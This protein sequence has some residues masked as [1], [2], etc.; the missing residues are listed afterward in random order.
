[1]HSALVDSGDICTIPAYLIHLIGL[2][3]RWK[4]WQEIAT[5]EGMDLDQTR[6]LTDT[7]EV[8]P[9]RADRIYCNALK[10]AQASLVESAQVRWKMDKHDQVY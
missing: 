8:N 2:F 4:I 3:V 9:I 10:E 6:L 5:A 1:M 7:Q